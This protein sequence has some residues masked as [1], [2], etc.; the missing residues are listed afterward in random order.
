SYSDQDTWNV[1]FYILSLR[2]QKSGPATQTQSLAQLQET[3]KLSDDQLLTTVSVT[4]D[5]ELEKKLFGPPD[6]K[7]LQISALRLHSAG[8][9]SQDSLAMARFK[10][11]D[12][13]ADYQGNHFE[14]ASQ[15]ALMAYV[16]GVEPVEPRLKA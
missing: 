16:E 13:L 12:A 2:Y 11:Q 3:L 9:T 6:Q 14:S 7:A 1:A 15:K 8:D 5:R 10:L 4:P